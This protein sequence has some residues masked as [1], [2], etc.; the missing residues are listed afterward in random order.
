MSPEAP[1]VFKKPF[2]RKESDRPGLYD[3]IR[4]AQPGRPAIHTGATIAVGNKDTNS[5]LCACWSLQCSYYDHCRE[6]LD[7][8][9]L[10]KPTS[11]WESH[12]SDSFLSLQPRKNGKLEGYRFK[13]RSRLRK[14]RGSSKPPKP[15][16]FDKL[17]ANGHGMSIKRT[18]WMAQKMY[19]NDM[20]RNYYLSS[21]GRKCVTTEQLC[22]LLMWMNYI[23]V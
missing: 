3:R 1:K 17:S 4:I 18:P 23:P 14:Y 11:V 21:C 7:T 6:Q 16:K 10:I 12:T 13:L 22:F 9:E 2:V 15:L 8:M 20:S 19:E 5:Q